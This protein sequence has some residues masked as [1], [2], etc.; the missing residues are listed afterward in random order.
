M[1]QKGLFVLLL[2]LSASAAYPQCTNSSGTPIVNETFGAGAALIGPP[3]PA[4]VT[5]MQYLATNCL[6]DGQYSIVNQASNCYSTWHTVSDHTGDQNG[7]FMLIN[8]SY[9]PSDFFVQTVNNLCPGTTYAF[10]AYILNMINVTNEILPN[11]TFTIENTT[12]GIL[13]SYNSG[14]I[15][16]TNPAK[17]VQYGFFFRTPNGVSSVVLR[18][19]NNA[20]G[21]TGND[22]AL[23][24][25]TFTPSGPKINVKITGFTTNTIHTL[26]N[27][28]IVINSSVGSCFTNNSYQWQSST[29]GTTWAD[30]PGATNAA[31]SPIIPTPGTYFYRLSVA[32]NGNIENPYCRANSD[33]VSITFDKAAVTN[34]T[35]MICSGSVYKLPSGNIISA[36]GVYA[37]TL[38]NEQGC[39]NS[40][41]NVNLT[42]KAIARSNLTVSACEGQSYLGYT[43]AGVYVDT[44]AGPDGCDSIR[45]LNLS[46]KQRSYSTLISTICQ[47][48]NY[49]G[50]TNSGSYIDTLVAANGCDSVRTI[51]LTVKPRSF[52]TLNTIICQGDNYLGY[53]KPGAYTDTLTSANGCDSI[54]TIN[55]AWY[56]APK[57]DFKSNGLVC[58][59]DTVILN[60]GTF[61]GYLWQDN[62]T[63]PYL[64]VTRAGTYW[65]KVTSAD[66]CTAADTVTLKEVYCGL[67]DIPNTFTPNGDGI[68]DTWNIYAL[69][70]YPNCKVLIY[71]RWGQLV[72]SSV[73][74][75]KA[76]DGLYNGKRLAVGT[77][78]YV[79]NL[80]NGG[81][82]LSGYITLL[83]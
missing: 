67:I 6:E 75:P 33:M 1:L 35:E 31:F 47:G 46:F 64:K 37:D 56:D 10:S 80:G 49:F 36:T 38:F 59:G 58:I 62:S 44:L 68:N 53:T 54:R 39:V 5:N 29:N 12:G 45:T 78:Y 3:L 74:Y 76:W 21:G 20:P 26:C 34:L 22:L 8:A 57:P 41:T 55:L 60:P 48:D 51:N 69:Q 11:I 16:V 66:G 40:I 82:P 7:Y 14:D 83:R 73:G 18:M 71:S 15:P 2:I 63:L 24:D 30:V 52:S 79:I 4:G 23:D 19:H 81:K 70:F 42:V 50:Y 25:I 43:K 28:N 61:D 9:Q 72:F 32:E 65:V 27:K 77:Y 13:A 17:W